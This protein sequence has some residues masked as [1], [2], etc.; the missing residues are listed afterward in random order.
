MQFWHIRQECL[1]NAYQDGNSPLGVDH[2]F[3]YL[4]CGAQIERK[5]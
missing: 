5:M 4:F 2:L 1:S 3:I